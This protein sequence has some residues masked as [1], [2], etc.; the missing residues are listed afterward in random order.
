MSAGL[1]SSATLFG[2]AAIIAN[3]AAAGVTAAVV[4]AIIE[5]L[6]PSV[7]KVES[8]W[9]ARPGDA[10]EL[11]RNVVADADVDLIVAVG[12]DGTVREVAEGMSRSVDR[13]G[14]TDPRG[15]VLLA[16]PGGSGNSTCRNLWGEIEWPEVLDLAL[17]SDR[18]ITRKL[19]LLRLVEADVDVLLGA[20][21]GF[22][23]EVLIGARGVTG[24]AGRERYYVAAADVLANM[25][26]HPT[27]VTVDGEVIHDG[28]A[29]LAAVGGG[30]FRAYAFQFLP[31]SVLDDG[32]LDVC[33]IEALTGSAVSEVADLVPTG[34]HLVR[35]E[36]TYRRGRRVC[37]ERTDG[38]PLLA[39]FDGEVWSGAGPTLTIEILPGAVAA[40]VR[41]DLPAG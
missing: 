7:I 32:E 27:R 21:S 8:H 39:E 31:C 22:L 11:A 34:G 26:A 41:R 16:L 24:V 18:S 13:S 23:A 37:I 15:P 36:V 35:P 12:G 6:H 3:P 14:G 9:T 28:P 19:D 30:R 5:R 1:R 25:P 33:V 20:S 2:R 29:S 10:V 38:Q 17:D 4:G 40:L